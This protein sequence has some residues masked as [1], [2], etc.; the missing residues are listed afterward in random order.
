MFR[1]WFLA[2]LLTAGP[3]LATP[4][5]RVTLSPPDLT[6]QPGETVVWNFM[7]ET[8]SNVWAV[9]N[10]IQFLPDTPM[11]GTLNLF[12]VEYPGVF[13]PGGPSS[14][15]YPGGGSGPNS[16]P[17]SLRFVGTPPS[18]TWNSY[19]ID[20]NAQPGDMV[21]GN[22]RFSFSLYSEVIIPSGYGYGYVTYF[23]SLGNEDVN[24]ATSIAVP[25]SGQDIPEASTLGMVVAG[26]AAV[27]VFRRRTS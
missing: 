8:F 27:L 3:A 26:L 15:G 6:G 2:A 5:V 12:W 14:G 13:G 1:F 24:V 20:P 17:P 25:L 22:L 21:S 9:V 23:S 16:I 19:N 7:I 4:N 10:D 11:I 18:G